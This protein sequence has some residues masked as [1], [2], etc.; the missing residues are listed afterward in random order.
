MGARS[1][2]EHHFAKFNDELVLKVRKLYDDG[3]SLMQLQDWLISQGYELCTSTIRAVTSREAW[4][5]VPEESVPR[6]GYR[7]GNA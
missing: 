2:T 5:H 1:G 4:K 3:M 6:K 7:R